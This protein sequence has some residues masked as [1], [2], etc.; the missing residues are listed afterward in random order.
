MFA[1]ST[2]RVFASP[3]TTASSSSLRRFLATAG[4]GAAI[5]PLRNYMSTQ[6]MSCQAEEEPQMLLILGKPGGGK[7][8]ISNKLLQVSE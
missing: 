2:M 5:M 1:R 7:G 8:T 6:P 3:T 4:K